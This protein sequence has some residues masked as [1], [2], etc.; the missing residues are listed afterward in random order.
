[1]TVK[2]GDEISGRFALKQNSRNNR[3]LDFIVKVD[4]Q[5]DMGELHEDNTYRMR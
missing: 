3:D 2:K 5:G 4:F 1:M